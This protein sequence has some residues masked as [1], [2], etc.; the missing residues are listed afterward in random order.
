MAEDEIGS[1]VAKRTGTKL[2]YEAKPGEV[3]RLLCTG[4]VV[5]AHPDRKPFIIM[6]DGTRK[7]L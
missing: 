2:I 1:V 4:A 6:P 5:V 3:T 7:T